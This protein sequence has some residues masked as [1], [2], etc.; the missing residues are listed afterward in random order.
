MAKLTLPCPGD[1]H[2]LVPKVRMLDF[3]AEVAYAEH[4]GDTF[5]ALRDFV[6]SLGLEVDV[7]ED[8][9]GI[10]LSWVDND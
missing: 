9:D 7:N 3:L 5:R 8:G 6:P 2:Y 10:V 4:N 1:D